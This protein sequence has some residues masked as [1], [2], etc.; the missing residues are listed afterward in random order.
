MAKSLRRFS[1]PKVRWR[2]RT[3]AIARRGISAAARAASAEKHTLVAV[4]GA[5]GF[6][7]LRRQGVSLPAFGPLTAEA[8]AGLVAWGIGKYTKN[9]MA[10]HLATGLLSVAAFDLASGGAAGTSGDS[11]EGDMEGDWMEGDDDGA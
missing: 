11:L 2:T 9:R 5:A 10:S 7:F 1:A 4:A 8:T 6:G 3:R